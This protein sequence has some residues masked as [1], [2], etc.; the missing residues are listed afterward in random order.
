MKISTT[1]FLTFLVSSLGIFYFVSGASPRQ[2]LSGLEPVRILTLREGDSLS[3]LEIQNQKSKETMALR[4]KGSDWMMETPVSYPAENFLIE[5]MVDALTFSRRTRRLPYQEKQAKEFGFHAPEIKI[6]LQTEKETK[7]RNLLFGEKS[8]V[9]AGIYAHWEGENEY[10][11]IPPEVKASFERTVYSLREKKLFQSRGEEVSG[12]DVKMP[13]GKE[14]R[15]E[16]K[17]EKWYW[18]R[19]PLAPEIPLE[20]VSELVYAFQFLYVK[21]FLDGA[22]PGGAEFGLQDSDAFLALRGREGKEERL[23][24]GA[25]EGRKE[26]LYTLREREKLVLLVSE[27]NLRALFQTFETTF[28]EHQSDHPRETL[29]SPREDPKGRQPGPEKPG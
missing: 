18:T 20:K 11:L 25:S 29:S 23:V 22:D 6:T 28:L 24:L 19:P 16:K 3:F 14:F 10:F 27:K 15:L 12:V 2:A 26:A 21:E 17:G 7:R 13:G 1:L 9:V 8:P 4:R 5:G